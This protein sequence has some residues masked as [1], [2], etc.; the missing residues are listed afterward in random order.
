M[1]HVCL[2]VISRR[3]SGRAGLSYAPD[4]QEPVSGVAFVPGVLTSGAEKYESNWPL[5]KLAPPLGEQVGTEQREG[6]GPLRQA[7]CQNPGNFYEDG[8]EKKKRTT[9]GAASECIS[10]AFLLSSSPTPPAPTPPPPPQFAWMCRLVFFGIAL[11][12]LLRAGKLTPLLLRTWVCA[13]GCVYVR[14]RVRELFL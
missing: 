11:T 8:K 1:A 9:R 7:F 2:Q 12:S 6:R 13:C 5:I 3:R 4:H 14:R 10:A